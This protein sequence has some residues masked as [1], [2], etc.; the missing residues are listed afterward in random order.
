MP[1]V[2]PI[3]KDSRK[4][5][6]GKPRRDRLKITFWFNFHFLVLDFL[7]LDF[8]ILHFALSCIFRFCILFISRFMSLNK[9]RGFVVLNS[10]QS[11]RFRSNGGVCLGGRAVK[12]PVTVHVH[13]QTMY[14]EI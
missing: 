10:G 3:P 6:I 7:V 8:L 12:S 4:A 1:S 13:A 11:E 2:T 14:P 5:S 9:F